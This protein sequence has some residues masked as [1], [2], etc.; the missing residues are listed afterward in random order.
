MWICV[1]YTVFD[2]ISPFSFNVVSKLVFIGL[3]T[4]SS[5]YTRHVSTNSK[6]LN[7]LIGMNNSWP[8]WKQ[9][10][11]YSECCG[12]LLAFIIH[13]WD[14]PLQAGLYHGSGSYCPSCEDRG[15][16]SIPVQFCRICGWHSNRTVIFSR[17]F[18]FLLSVS[19]NQQPRIIHSYFTEAT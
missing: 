15:L 6:W 8:S 13:N 19:F 4:V 12:R 17:H 2:E 11:F 9:V 7:R 16:C 18:G 5:C 1:L 10:S 14:M 3:T